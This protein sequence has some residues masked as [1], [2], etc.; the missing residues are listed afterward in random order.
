MLSLV[1]QEGDGLAGCR[2]ELVLSHVFQLV[3]GDSESDE[4]GNI[5]CHG[6][7]EVV[8]ANQP[9]SRVRVLE[10]NVAPQRVAM[11]TTSFVQLGQA[12]HDDSPISTPFAI[13]DA[14]LADVT[15]LE[16][17]FKRRCDGGDIKEIGWPGVYQFSEPRLVVLYVMAQEHLVQGRRQRRLHRLRGHV[18][19]DFVKLVGAR[20]RPHPLFPSIGSRENLAADFASLFPVALIDQFSD[21]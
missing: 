21:P 9:E 7:R 5:V 11:P 18:F 17:V 3:G 14:V 2:H 8:V 4:G 19:G 12:F 20:K 1:N 16:L 10:P 13:L 15:V 6:I